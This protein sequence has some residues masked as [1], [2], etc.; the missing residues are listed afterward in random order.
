MPQPN[1]TM[2][3]MPMFDGATPATGASTAIA[4]AL[5]E[6]IDCTPNMNPSEGA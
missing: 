3:H 6:T 5:T 2:V 1:S 4:A